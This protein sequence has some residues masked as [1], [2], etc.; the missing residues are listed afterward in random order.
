MA[1]SSHVYGT[2]SPLT[3]NGFGRTGYTFAGWARTADATTVEFANGANV[4]TLTPNDGET[5]TLYAVWAANAY[6]VSYDG[7]GSTSGSMANSSHVYGTPSPLTLNGFGRTGYTF[8]GW[9]RT[10]DAATA[11]YADGANVSTLTAVSDVPV[12]LYA[13]WTPI[14]YTVEYDGNGSDGGDTADS[15]H[16]YDAASA[17][18]ANGFTLTGYTFAGWAETAGGT[19]VYADGADVTNLTAVGG[20]TVTLYA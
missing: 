9:A 4:S 3:L 11:E 12:I 8:T 13:V 17:L 1:N 14:S 10:A 15:H 16:T 19:V 2:P 6:T 18:T 20:G 7:N 5:V